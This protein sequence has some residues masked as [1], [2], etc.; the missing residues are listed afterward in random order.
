MSGGA[1]VDRF[2]FTTIPDSIG[3]VDTVADFSA[4]DD[5]FNLDNAV[6]SA[7]GL[8]TGLLLASQ[9]EIGASAAD[10]SDRVIYNAATG[11]L[12]YDADGT[13]AVAQIQ[14]ATVSPGLALTSSHFVVV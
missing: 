13:G 2:E 5:L 12:F 4:A 14:F 10:A 1:G 11:A 8:A 3:N 7:G 6:F 9:F